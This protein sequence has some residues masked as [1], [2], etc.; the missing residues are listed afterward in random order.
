[1][2]SEKSDRIKKIRDAS[3]AVFFTLATIFGIYAF[4]MISSVFDNSSAPSIRADCGNESAYVF[5]D[6]FGGADISNVKCTALDNFFE[7]KEVIL[8]SISKSSKDFCAF[9]VKEQATKPARFDVSYNEEKI[10]TV[11]NSGFTGGF[12]D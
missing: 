7:Q 12:I 9:D 5:I 10:R 2:S 1:M 6:N 11:C 4:V 8:G 3:I